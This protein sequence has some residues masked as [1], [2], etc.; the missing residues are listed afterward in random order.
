MK[1]AASSEPRSLQLV[2]DADAEREQVERFRATLRRKSRR[3]AT[4][5]TA[6]SCGTSNT[7]GLA[8]RD[9]SAHATTVWVVPR[10]IPT[11]RGLTDLRPRGRPV[12]DPSLMGCPPRPHHGH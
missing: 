9:A 2:W 3:G 4:S 12:A 7:A 10:S 6:T 11:T 1:D 5:P 8:P